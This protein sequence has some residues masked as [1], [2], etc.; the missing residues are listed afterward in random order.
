MYATLRPIELER[1]LPY[2][3]TLVPCDEPTVPRLDDMARN[4]VASQYHASRFDGGGDGRLCSEKF[5][6]GG[7]GG[8]GWEDETFEGDD[9]ERL[10]AS[11]RHES[12]SEDS[13]DGEDDGS[14]DSDN[15]DRDD[16]HT[17]GG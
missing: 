5:K 1:E 11:D 17:R 15:D 8:E 13:E 16:E 6:D 12:S 10:V 9:H 7:S 2:I 4:S 3:S 14:I